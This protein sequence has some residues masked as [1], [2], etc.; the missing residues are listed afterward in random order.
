ME[1][2]P[3]RQPVP[4]DTRLADQHEAAKPERR[5]VQVRQTRS[6]VRVRLGPADDRGS[7]VSSHGE[8]A[9]GDADGRGVVQR[10]PPR[11][12]LPS[13]RADEEPRLLQSR[14]LQIPVAEILR[15]LEFLEFRRL[16]P[17]DHSD[18]HVQQPYEES[19]GAGTAAGQEAG[20]NGGGADRGDRTED[21]QPAS[22]LLE[23]E[24]QIHRRPG[25]GQGELQLFESQVSIHLRHRV[26]QRL[27]ANDADEQRHVPAVRCL[28]RPSKA[29]QDWSSDSYRRDDRQDR[30]DRE[31]SLPAVVRRAKGAGHRRDP[32]V[33]VHLVPEMGQLQTGDLSAVR[34]C[35]QGPSVPLVQGP[36]R[37]RVHGGEELRHAQQQ[38]TRHIQQAGTEEGLRRVREGSGLPSRGSVRE[39]GGVDR[40][41]QPA[42]RGQDLLLPAAGS[43]ERDEDFRPL[44]EVGDGP[45]DSSDAARRATERP[46]ISTHVSDEKDQSQ[47]AERTDPLQRLPVQAHVRVRVHRAAGRGR[48]DHAGERRHVAGSD[49]EGDGESA[50]D[51]ERDQGLV[52]R[53]ERVLS[54]R[55]AAL[56]RVLQRHTKVS[57]RFDASGRKPNLSACVLI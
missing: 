32:R 8:Q 4:I 11:R 25:E 47:E 17:S 45:R 40:A 29:V 12:H 49:E 35:L 54:R 44:S 1:P 5:W 18:H 46:C 52:Q 20:E 42:G 16:Q 13:T 3:D 39:T 7:A 55:S 57:S 28:L 19:A 6:A 15:G 33:Q 37:L 10:V 23:Q 51:Q 43:S 38:S 48:G 34:D 56:A 24:Q 26:Q 21:T 14:P 9:E 2:G 41:D 50:E 31:D 27:L 53:E 22:G 30:A 36:A